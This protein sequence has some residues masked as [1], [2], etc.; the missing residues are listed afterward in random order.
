MAHEIFN[1]LP[2]DQLENICRQYH[3]I[4][5]SV[6]GSALR[7][8]FRPESDIDL[9]V[10]FDPA[11]QIGFFTL[12]KLQREFSRLFKRT[13]DLIPKQGLKP[14]IRRAVLETAKVIYAT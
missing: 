8:D 2:K 7:D 11:A 4:E 6:F 9:L 3:V 12:I 10:E 5:V 14:A 13:V 1:D